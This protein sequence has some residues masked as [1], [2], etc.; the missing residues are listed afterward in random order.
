[1]TDRLLKAEDVADLLSVSRRWV[2]DATR[3][4]EIPHVRL[5][6]SIRYRPETVRAWIAEREDG[7]A[8]RNKLRRVH[9]G[10]TRCT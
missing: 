1:V 9:T 8:A 2:E 10:G 7:S 5:G 4:G 6:R 3:R